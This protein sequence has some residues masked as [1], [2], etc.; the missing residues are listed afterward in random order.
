VLVVYAHLQQTFT[1]CD[2][3][4]SAGCLVTSKCVSKRNGH[5]SIG[6]QYGETRAWL[7]YPSRQKWPGIYKVT[8]DIVRTIER[9]YHIKMAPTNTCRNCAVKDTLQ[10]R[11]TVCGGGRHMGIRK[12]TRGANATDDANLDARLDPPS[13]ASTVAS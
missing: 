3:Y 6:R 10:H 8:H 5:K 12:G 1:H 9:Q 7:H 11:L 13:S 2:P 4:Q